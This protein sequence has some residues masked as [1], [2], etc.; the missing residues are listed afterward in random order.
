MLL[1]VAGFTFFSAFYYYKAN[2]QTPTLSP[3]PEAP[4]Q[5]VACTEEAKICPDGSAVGRTGPNCEFAP[6]PT[7]AKFATGCAQDSDCVATCPRD[8][9]NREAAKLGQRAA[10]LIKPTHTCVCGI[11][12]RCTLAQ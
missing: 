12:Q 9:L 11:D 8:C 6:C 7:V 10:C 5:G 1:L 3:T 2:P 4:A